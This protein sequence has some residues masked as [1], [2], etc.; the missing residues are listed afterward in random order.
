MANL[1]GKCPFCYQDVSVDLTNEKMN[2]T[3][4]GQ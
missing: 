1:V 4:C 3:A 2:C